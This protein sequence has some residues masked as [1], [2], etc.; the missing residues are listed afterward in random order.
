MVSGASDSQKKSFCLLN[1]M[2]FWGYGKLKSFSF[3]VWCR[4][5]NSTF[6]K[7]KVHKRRRLFWS[8]S[9][10]FF[11]FFSISQKIFLWNSFPFV[12]NLSNTCKSHWSV[13]INLSLFLVFCLRSAKW[14]EDKLQSKKKITKLSANIISH[15]EEN[16]K[17]WRQIIWEIKK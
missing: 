12:R 9:T 6:E 16:G 8:H 15:H 1:E 4:D 11:V 13:P 7:I 17:K 5:R 2:M 14:T 3:V 10:N